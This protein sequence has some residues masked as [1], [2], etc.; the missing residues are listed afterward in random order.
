MAIS[1]KEQFHTDFKMSRTLLSRGWLPILRTDRTQISPGTLLTARLMG[2]GLFALLTWAAAWTRI[3][4]PGTPVPMTFQ[5]LAVLLSGA[6]LGPFRGAASQVLYLGLGLIGLPVF[7]G[8]GAGWAYLAG[9][10][11]GYLVGFVL[12]SLFVGAML[13]KQREP[14]ILKLGLVVLAGSLIISCAGVLFLALY[15]GGNFWAALRQGALIFT[16]W[17]LLKVVAAAGG[18]RLL[19]PI[20]RYLQS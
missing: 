12:A 1:G 3:P 8:S 2:I 17:D 5:T 20:R 10:T 16:P 11:A 4:I 19:L 13:G 9:P 7:A 15:M 14:G 18:A 6:V